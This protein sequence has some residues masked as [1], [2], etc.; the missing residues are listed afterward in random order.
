MSMLGGS[1][2]TIKICR[3]FFSYPKTQKSFQ[4]SRAHSAKIEGSPGFQTWAGPNNLNTAGQNDLILTN[5]AYL[6][7]TY[8]VSA[9][10]GF[11]TLN[12]TIHTKCPGP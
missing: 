1:F 3:C 11:L 7:N 2:L 9:I 8:K 10:V 12:F 5:V 4:I 6:Q